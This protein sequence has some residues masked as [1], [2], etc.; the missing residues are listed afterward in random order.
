MKRMMQFTLAVLLI[1]S[2]PAIGQISPKR[3]VRNVEKK[4]TSAK[5]LKIAFEEKFIW[6]LTG[7]QQSIAGD[8]LLEKDDRFRVTTEDQVIVSNG[9][10]LWTYSEPS[11]RVLID[12]CDPKEESLY[13]RRILFRYTKDYDVRLR[14][15]EIILEKDCY[16]LDF[17]SS[18]GEDYF[19]QVVVWV[20]KKEWIPRKVEQ[21][22]LDDN[23][24][25]YLLKQMIFDEEL[26]KDTFKFV[27]PK[28]AEVI[29]MR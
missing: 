19:P 17:E 13:P 24:T 25:I 5:T 10:T 4:L 21:I 1:P 26:P 11:D 9:K 3:I 2:L 12:V 8:L 20:D 7:E 29:D 23:R 27:I 18:T 28:G 14:G 22:D 15:E 16:I 6:T